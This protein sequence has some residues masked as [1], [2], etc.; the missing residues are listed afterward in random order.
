MTFQKLQGPCRRG[1][2]FRRAHRVDRR[3]LRHLQGAL[4]SSVLPHPAPLTPSPPIYRVHVSA[5]PAGA[6]TA[7]GHVY[8]S[9][10]SDRLGLRLS[11]MARSTRRGTPRPCLS[12]LFRASTT[13]LPHGSVAHTA[14]RATARVRR[15]TLPSRSRAS[16]LASSAILPTA[17]MARRR[18]SNERLQL[19]V[20][21]LL[22]GAAAPASARLHLNRKR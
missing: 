11:S 22:M 12:L 1:L 20:T 13:P 2:L 16:H 5:F 4:G 21:R 9:S 18:P 3:P 15:S 19:T 10:S 7:S 17:P 14:S 6:L 8:R